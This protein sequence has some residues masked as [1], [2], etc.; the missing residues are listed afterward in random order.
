LLLAS[1]KGGAGKSTLARAFAVASLR[2]GIR[3]ALID[4]DPSR[5]G[6]EVGPAT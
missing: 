1:Q 3:T 4:A 6:E 2:A 5:L